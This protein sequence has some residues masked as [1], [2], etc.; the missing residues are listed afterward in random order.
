MLVQLV[1]GMFTNK[2]GAAPAGGGAATAAAAAPAP[3]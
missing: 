3:Q 1:I 2:A